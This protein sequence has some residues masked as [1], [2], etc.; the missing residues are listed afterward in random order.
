MDLS[1]IILSSH[2]KPTPPHGVESLRHLK[3]F[4]YEVLVVDDSSD[5]CTPVPSAGCSTPTP[6]TI[7]RAANTSIHPDLAR[8][9]AVFSRAQGK[10]LFFLRSDDQPNPL[11]LE[12][13]ISALEK[14]PGN[15]VAI[16]AIEPWGPLTSPDVE[17]DRLHSLAARETLRRTRSR[18]TLV[19]RLLFF[20]PILVV[21]SCIIRRDLFMEIGGFNPE[22]PFYEDVDLYIRAIRRRGFVYV[23]DVITKHAAHPRVPHLESKQNPQLIG[24]CYKNLSRSYKKLYGRSEYFGL[25]LIATALE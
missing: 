9:K 12:K 23:D 6:L 2:E 24:R 3:T 5:N 4:T 16:A 15:G 25:R 17:G 13:M 10:Y 11:V 20:R 22:I 8:N 7:G 19:S 14:R 1:V 18:I 21:S